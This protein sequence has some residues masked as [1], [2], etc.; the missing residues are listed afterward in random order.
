MQL[1]LTKKHNVPRHGRWLLT[2]LH[3]AVLV[4]SAM[5]IVWITRDT[6]QNVS[7][8]SN[9]SY[10]RFQGWVCVLFLIDI[11]VETI[12]APRKW[13]YILSHCLFIIVSIPY[14]N[15]IHYTGIELGGEVSYLLRFLPMIRAG[16]VLALVSGALS[17]NAALNSFWVYTIWLIA[18]IYFA[19]LMFF[20]EEH[21]INPGVDSI[22]SALWWALM[23]M[24]TTGSN[25][26]EMTVT[27]QA[28]STFLS[29]EGLMLFPVF[30][31]YITKAVIHNSDN[32]NDKRQT[33]GQ[34]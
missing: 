5:M 25:I 12:F 30:T 9:P 15:I 16:Y 34:S 26:N 1:Y 10:L 32:P 24:T 11:V 22:W 18:S 17:S 3:I 21:Y 6:L 4:A 14:L 27:G 23:C 29:A 7:F 13:K 19:G 33:A 28:L 8:I 2:I 31:V 20:V